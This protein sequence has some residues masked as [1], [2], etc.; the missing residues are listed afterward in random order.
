[1][2]NQS[3]QEENRKTTPKFK[4]KGKENEEQYSSSAF[5]SSFLSP[6]CS[7]KK[8]MGLTPNSMNI[9]GEV[10]RVWLVV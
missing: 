5:P 8:V 9:S 4:Q 6:L 2:A 10:S 1:M 3:A 7:R